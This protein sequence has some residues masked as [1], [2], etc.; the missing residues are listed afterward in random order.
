MIATAVFLFVLNVLQF[1]MNLAAHETGWAL[2]MAIGAAACAGI[3]TSEMLHRKPCR[4]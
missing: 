1:V 3:V 2:A 4:Q